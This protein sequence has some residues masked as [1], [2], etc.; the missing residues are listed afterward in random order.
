MERDTIVPSI[1]ISKNI[2]IGIQYTN[3]YNQPNPKMKN[4][5][6]FLLIYLYIILVNQNKIIKEEVP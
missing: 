3:P 2:G 6:F 1:L 4:K 5:F